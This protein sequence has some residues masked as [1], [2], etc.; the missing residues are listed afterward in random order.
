M[1]GEYCFCVSNILCYST[2][3]IWYST[4]QYS[5]QNIPH[6]KYTALKIY[7]TQNIQHSTIQHTKYTAHKIYSTLHTAL[8]IQ[9]CIQYWA[10]ASVPHAIC[11]GCG[12]WKIQV[13]CFSSRRGSSH[14][15]GVISIWHSIHHNQRGLICCAVCI[16]PAHIPDVYAKG[17]PKLIWI[18]FHSTEVWWL[19]MAGQVGMW[20]KK[21]RIIW[22]L[23]C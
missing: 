14:S 6:T 17:H 10:K 7:S 18:V 23:T 5:T 19:E 16:T 13:W 1:F 2:S 9:H 15:L 3:H 4:Q 20:K 22:Y 12:T 21:K 8:C 11:H